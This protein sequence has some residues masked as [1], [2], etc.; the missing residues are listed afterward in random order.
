MRL[1]STTTPVLSLPN[2]LT[3]LPLKRH[4][5]FLPCSTYHGPPV[6]SLLG[7][8]RSLP[9]SAPFLH[10]PHSFDTSVGDDVQKDLHAK[11][12]DTTAF[13]LAIPNTSV[14]C[15]SFPSTV[16]YTPRAYKSN[17]WLGDPL[18]APSSSIHIGDPFRIHGDP[19][20]P[21]RSASAMS[22]P[23]DEKTAGP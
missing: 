8:P 7:R 19:P 22:C 21:R 15:S 3:Y 4:A 1:R 10:F 11:E 9:A 18:V 2:R 13:C 20:G 6:C 16:S 12:W 17:C 14:G 5:L 23:C